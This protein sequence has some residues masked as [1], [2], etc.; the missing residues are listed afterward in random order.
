M[1]SLLSSLSFTAS[2]AA[3]VV[4]VIGACVLLLNTHSLSEDRAAAPA[5]ALPFALI[6]LLIGVRSQT[7]AGLPLAALGAL[8]C[9]ALLLVGTLDLMVSEQRVE[10]C[11]LLLLGAGGA[12]AL[13]TAT[14]LLQA[15]VGQETLALSAVIL[16]ALARGERALEAAFKYFVLGAISL[17]AL[18]YGIGLV[19]L[20]TGSFAFPTQAQVS[21]S[22][23]VLGGAVLVALGFAFELAV[24]PLH[25]GAL[26]AY[27]AAAPGI[28]G[29]VMSS[30][31]LGAAL[32]LGHLLLA[33]GAPVSEVLTWM[34]CATIVWGTFG[35]LAQRELR[36]MLAYS[37]ITHAGIIAVAVSAGLAGP[38]TAAFYAA[39][40]AAMAM[41]VFG[42][43]GGH[44]SE[45]LPM[46]LA[47]GSELG[48]LRSAALALG[49]L[50]LS[51]IPPTP[52][53]WAKLAAITVAWHALGFIPGIIVAGG[54]VF[55]VLYYLRP[56]PD[57]FATVREAARPTLPRALGTST[58]VVI[59]G[60]VVVALGLFPGLIWAL[61]LQAGRGG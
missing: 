59:A 23:V 29:F 10:A 16:V 42:A 34:G 24:F 11:A 14:D 37:A 3:V 58:G 9:I 27:T 43:L 48:P 33:A 53:F 45:P 40:Y 8:T 61:A 22:P 15:V 26:D 46:R 54:G 25:W 39:I 55:S 21:S 57:L 7:A 44:T 47:R 5:V 2:N 6:A 32:A 50:S 13:A 52:G 1:T 12:V 19:F 30:S 36:R 31:K 51:G 56:I 60:L 38:L 17:A 35:A 20:G 4:L 49:L 28:A 18:L 41:L